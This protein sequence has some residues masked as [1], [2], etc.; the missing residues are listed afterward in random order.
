[1]KEVIFGDAIRKIR[2]ERGLTQERLAE[3]ICSPSSLSRIE[4]GGQV[5]SRKTFQLLMERLDGPGYSYAHFLS[6]E[7]YHKE[8]VKENLLAALEDEDYEA[9]CDWLGELHQVL[10][11]SDIKLRQFFEMSKLICFSM[12]DEQRI[13]G[14]YAN[15]CKEIL[16]MGR[17]D[18]DVEES[19]K[20]Y[21]DS[22]RIGRAKIDVRK[23]DWWKSG[24]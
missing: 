7:E 4:N 17:P 22:L 6:P 20:Q 21:E 12:G 5:P 23:K 24:F 8:I 13:R 14:D 11:E 1:M 3:G 16:E 2:I 10:D 19:L 18:W 15:A 9:A